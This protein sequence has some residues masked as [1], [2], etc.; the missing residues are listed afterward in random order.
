[1]K[2]RILAALLFASSCAIPAAAQSGILVYGTY[3]ST[4]FTPAESFKA[5]S[6]TARHPGFGGGVVENRV[7]RGLFAD[8]GIFQTKVKG[9]RVFMDSGTVYKL[10]IPLQVTV[11]PIDFVGGW[12][13]TKDRLSTFA[14]GRSVVGDVQRNRGLRR[15]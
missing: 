12:R 8:I 13:L 3:A 2:L 9:E 14:R 10:G 11:T 4:A 15:G 6:G 1:M 5:V 7:W